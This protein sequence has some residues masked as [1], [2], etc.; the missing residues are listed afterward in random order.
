[1]TTHCTHCETGPGYATPLDAYNKGPREKIV[2]VIAI[3]T[4]PKKPDALVTIDVDPSSKAYGTIIHELY[5]PNLGDELH[6]FG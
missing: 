6:H 3:S 1:M 4:D 2:Y 5:V